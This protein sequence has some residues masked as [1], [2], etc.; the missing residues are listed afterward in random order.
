[1]V[2]EDVPETI[3]PA[4]VQARLKSS[5]KRTDNLLGP[6]TELLY[7]HR[8]KRLPEEKVTEIMTGLIGA[9]AAQ[10]LLC[11]GSDDQRQRV[12]AKWM[13]ATWAPN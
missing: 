4:A 5:A 10:S 8:E 3:D 2:W 12:I 7:Y 13:P 9:E 1:M 6:L 11:G